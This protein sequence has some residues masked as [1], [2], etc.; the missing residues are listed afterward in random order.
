[1]H[2]GASTVLKLIQSQH[3][4]FCAKN[5]NFLL[6]NL[7]CIISIIVWRIVLFCVFFIIRVYLLSVLL[8]YHKTNWSGLKCLLIRHVWP[9]R[10]IERC[11]WLKLQLDLYLCRPIKCSCPAG[12][13]MSFT[14]PSFSC[15]FP[16]ILSE[17]HIWLLFCFR[18]YV[19]K[20]PLH[21]PTCAV[22]V[23]FVH[24]ST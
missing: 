12:E 6:C 8:F 21:L 13:V 18:G 19:R 16:T 22:T 5:V 17:C 15:P 4:F 2:E 14:D 20:S 1:M 24:F 7:H 3:L 9:R 11:M 10:V 23:L